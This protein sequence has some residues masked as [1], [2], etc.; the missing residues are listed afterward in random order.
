M[1]EVRD[2][3]Y[4]NK[5][6]GDFRGDLIEYAKNYFPETYNDFSPGS[7]GMMF[8][9]MASY[10]GDVLSFYQDTQ[11]QETFLQYA[12][13]PSNLYS[14]A[15]MMGY[16]PKVI[17]ASEVILE[18]SQVLN[19]IGG[20]YT[21]DW[22]S[23][24]FIQPNAQI[25]ATIGSAPIFTIPKSIDFRFSSSYDPTEVQITTL[26][27]GNPA[28][29]TV[30]KKIKAISG[31]I[32]TVN[33]SISDLKKFRTIN[34]E[35]T[36]IIGIV[37]IVDSDDNLWY[38]VP[39][40]GQESVYI[41]QSNAEGD[42]GEVPYKIQLQKVP[43]RYVSRFTSTGVLQIQFGSGVGGIDDSVFLPNPTNVGLGTAA[44]S[45]YSGSLT[46]IDYAYDPSNFLYSNTY[47]LAP[48]TDLTIRYLVGGGVQSNVPS[49]TI[50]IQESVD[51]SEV[52]SFNNPMASYG[53]RDGDTV[54]ELRQNS[55]RSYAEQGRV[56][57]LQDYTVRAL[58]LP[59]SY[60]SIAK[61]YVTQDQATNSNYED[62]IVDNN[63]LSLSMYTLAYDIDK[64][65]INST[66]NLKNNLKT[67]LSQYM[68]LTDS[69]NIKDAFIINIGL[70]YD[71]I[72]LPNY[73]G[74]DVLTSCTRALIDYFEISKWRINQPINISK[75]YTLLDRVK[76]V[77]TVQKVVI[78]NKQGG[79]YSQ[80]AYDI[81]GATKNNIVYPSYDPSIFEIKFPLT[82]IEGRITS[83]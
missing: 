8:I 61:V 65:L 4:V 50:T 15:Y 5:E 27:S 79:N 63:P 55:M 44:D 68:M 19:A 82:D 20:S 80:F 71:V 62:S 23:A 54:E 56:V 2:I 48:T 6:F 39:F 60:G 13:D 30:K 22:A 40:L 14:L 59:S 12:K 43:R 17:G 42:S 47:G 9:E 77:Q 18:V 66:I 7:P 53:G 69:L 70:Q 52:V 1:A 83:A 72:S 25:K 26:N 51:T 58:S 16:R 36:N 46:R 76:G 11:L 33:Y 29:Y 41:E 78:T 74:R 34:I 49:N 81:P 64:K 31:E 3:K 57:T 75:I 37:D 32:K 67:Y 35:D 73:A 45:S 21:P 24:A 38:E 10:V 28:T